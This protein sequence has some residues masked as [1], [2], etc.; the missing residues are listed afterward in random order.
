MEFYFV[1]RPLDSDYSVCGLADD[2]LFAL[3]EAR[4]EGRMQ[5]MFKDLGGYWRYER[6]EGTEVAVFTMDEPDPDTSRSD[7]IHSPAFACSD[8]PG[9]GCM[10]GCERLVDTDLFED[11]E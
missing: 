4:E 10:S 9:C 3:A 2:F 1:W 7:H 8:Y 5:D 11:A 6:P